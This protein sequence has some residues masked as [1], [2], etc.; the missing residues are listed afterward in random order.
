MVMRNDAKLL[1][2]LMA[3]DNCKQLD[4]DIAVLKERHPNYH[5]LLPLIRKIYP[6]DKTSI[7]KN[8]TA[9]EEELIVCYASAVA[10]EHSKNKTSTFGLSKPKYKLA[11]TQA[12]IV[13]YN[14]FRHPTI[15]VVKRVW[16]LADKEELSNVDL[17][18]ISIN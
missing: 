17:D 14:Y 13:V 1:Y 9:Y 10:A 8:Y 12:S 7:A 18:Y 5:H 2:I 16:N 15:E 11:T 4:D 3:I 6:K